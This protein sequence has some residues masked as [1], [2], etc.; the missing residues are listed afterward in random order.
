[1]WLAS[2]TQVFHWNGTELQLAKQE[3]FNGTPPVARRAVF[4]H[5]PNDIWVA[6]NGHTAHWDGE[7]WTEEDS[8][9]KAGTFASGPQGFFAYNLEGDI[10][11]RR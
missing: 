2:A 6:G 11:R 10:A 8:P 7:M 3:T 9:V 1:V 4:A 5:A